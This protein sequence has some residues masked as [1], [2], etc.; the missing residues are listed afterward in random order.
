[1]PKL[2]DLLSESNKKELLSEARKALTSKSSD[3]SHPKRKTSHQNDTV[4]SIDVPDFIAFDLETTGLDFRNDRVIEIGA[5]RFVNGKPEDEFSTFVNPGKPVPPLIT[6]LT[7]ISD[8][9]LTSAPT[10]P[11]ITEKLLQFIGDLPLC[12]H[13]IEFDATFLNEELKRT[14]H[15][16]FSG[17][18]LDTALLSR[19]LLQGSTRF[20]LK[21][22]S[23]H[24]QINLDNAHRALFDAKASGEVAVRLINKINGLPLHIRQTIAACAPGSLFKSL[25]IKSLNGNRAHVILRLNKTENPSTRLQEP[26]KYL[27]VDKNSIEE[28]FSDNGKLKLILENFTPRHSQTDMALQVADTLNTSSILIAEA[29]TGTGKSLAYLLPSSQWAIANNCRVLICTRTKNLQDQLF[30]KDLPL[31]KKLLDEKLRYTVLKGRNNYIC[32]N[33]WEKLLRGEIGNI[34]PRERFAILPLIPWVEKTKTGDIEEQNQFNPKWFSK[35]WNLISA[36]SYECLSRRCTR[37]QHCFFQKARQQALSSNIVIIN[38]ALFFSEICSESSFLG[39]IGTII[40]VEAHHL[41]SCGHRFLRVELD[42]ARINLFL[43]MINNLVLKTGELK[44]EEN[45]YSHGKELRNILKHMRKRSQKFIAEL[46]NW[47]EKKTDSSDYQISYYENDLN[48]LSEPAALGT[49]ISELVDRLFSL[50]QV[51]SSDEYAK[52]FEDLS[53]QVQTCYEKASQLKADL[54]YLLAAKTEEHVF[55]LEGSRT[56]NWVKLCGVPLDIGGI[57]SEVWKRCNGGVIFTSATISICRSVDY[58]KRAVGLLDHDHRTVAAFF[59]SPFGAHQSIMGAVKN[60]PEPDSPEFPAFVADT[61]VRLHTEFNKNILVL[62]TANSMLN[63]VNDLLRADQKIDNGKILAQ[64][65]SGSRQNILEQFRANQRMILLGTESFWEGIDVPGE[66][67]E[68]VIIP[69]LPFPVPSHPLTLAI[70]KRMEQINGESFFSYSV[71]EAIIKYRQGAGRLIRTVNDRGAL[72]VLDNRILTKGYGK[73]FIRALEGDFKN[74]EDTSTMI[75]SIK[76]FFEADP[77]AEVST[78]KYIPLED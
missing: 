55:W 8:K 16:A 23:E 76:K 73:Q 36:D 29:G 28:L 19:I 66:A 48:S 38:H 5:L 67:C 64:G 25:M 14:G 39:K 12:G 10:F 59:Q 2:F 42:T 31:V 52:K 60:S 17:Q 50:R 41:E 40:F 75:F 37:F 46:G 71:P 53:A 30:T 11:E 9:E 18:L 61:I 65:A 49:D 57:L 45:I 27:P 4:Y 69:R 21:A 34:S 3:K 72:I 70:C 63:A 74:F 35:I 15:S 13:Q 54:A 58:F 43:D 47:V 51:L 24:L 77:S 62:F 7:G 6:D 68:I 78:L 56:K 1:M 22:V 20:S 33:R 44:G 26:E 32:I